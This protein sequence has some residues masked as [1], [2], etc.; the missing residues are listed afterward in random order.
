MEGGEGHLPNSGDRFWAAMARSLLK[1]SWTDMTGHYE[2][3]D[4]CQSA[5]KAHAQVRRNLSVLATRHNPF[6]SVEPQS[7]AV[8]QILSR[9]MQLWLPAADA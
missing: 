4:Y 2:V 6:G 1:G 5:I 8:M 9:T 3:L 7:G